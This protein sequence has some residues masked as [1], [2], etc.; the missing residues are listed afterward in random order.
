VL[1]EGPNVNSYVGNNPVGR[2][3]ELGLKQCGFL[4]Q[5]TMHGTDSALLN[6]LGSIL[7]G[8]HEFYQAEDGTGAGFGGTGQDDPDDPLISHVPIE[9]P[10]N[11]CCSCFS[12][13]VKK[14]D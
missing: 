3:D 6:F 4:V 9:I 13:C 5:Q 2:I 8:W 1:K 10:D 14:K 11:I 7:G 12:D